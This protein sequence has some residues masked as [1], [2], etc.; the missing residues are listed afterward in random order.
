[1]SRYFQRIIKANYAEES[2]PAIASPDLRSSTPAPLKFN[3]SRYSVNSQCS[4]FFLLLSSGSFSAILSDNFT[5]FLGALSHC[6]DKQ[7]ILVL[8][9]VKSIDKVLELALKV[10]AKPSLVLLPKLINGQETP[11]QADVPTDTVGAD[12]ALGA[13]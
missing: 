3:E 13:H 6:L 10:Q 8:K 11:D 9:L 4:T 7:D 1:M 5:T 2:L 12:M